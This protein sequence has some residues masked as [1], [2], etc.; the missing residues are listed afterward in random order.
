MKKINRK[1]EITASEHNHIL[2]EFLAF[3]LHENQLNNIIPLL[4]IAP[5]P[6]LINTEKPYTIVIEPYGTLVLMKNGKIKVR[7]YVFELLCFLCHNFSVVLWSWM[8]PT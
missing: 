6:Y 7:P 8:M 2:F 1:K 3:Y 5:N 4:D